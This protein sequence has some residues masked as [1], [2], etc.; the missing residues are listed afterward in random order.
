MES[1]KILTRP[2]LQKP[3]LIAGF[4]GWPNA[5]EVSSGV[6]RYLIQKLS[7]R[8][9][10]EI[11]WEEYF[12]ACDHRPSAVVKD[13][14]VVKVVLPENS[15]YYSNVSPPLILFL[16][17]EPQFRWRGYSAAFLDLCEELQ[18]RTIFTVGGTLDYVLHSAQPKISGLVN[19]PKLIL[20]L[21]Q[22]SVH[23]AEYNGP[24]SIHT[25]IMEEAGKRNIPCISL[26]GHAPIYIQTGH[27]RVF[28]SIIEVIDSILGLDLDYS[29]LESTCAELD[30]QIDQLIGEN[31]KLQ[32]YLNALKAQAG[33]L[34]PNAPKKYPKVKGGGKIIK[35]EEF[36]KRHPDKIG[37]AEGLD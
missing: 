19:H 36:L 5:G 25:C 27:V 8:K 23:P 32:E 26:W 17:E 4:L 6:L 22:L 33:Y 18:V 35:L 24:M 7:G 1:I 31:P 30:R 10:A 15:F 34:S 11:N 13:G 21:G 2:D 9:F 20:P 29:D 16:G 37:P 3:H 12:N 14:L 28:I